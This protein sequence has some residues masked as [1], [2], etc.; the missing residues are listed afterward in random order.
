MAFKAFYQ[1]W[2]MV[3]GPALIELREVKGKH[4]LKRTIV[5]DPETGKP[6]GDRRT[7]HGE[8]EADPRRW[9]AVA[10]EVSDEYERRVA[11]EIEPIRARI[12]ALRAALDEANGELI[13][14]EEELGRLVLDVA[15]PVVE[16][17]YFTSWKRETAEKEGT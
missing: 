2:S 8:R 17:P 15:T 12:A 9:V 14:K 6:M 7:V 5:I 16:S 1:N 10:A 11:A 13:E 4:G 3:S